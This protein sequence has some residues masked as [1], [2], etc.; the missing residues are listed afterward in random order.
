MA[1]FALDVLVV[2]AFDSLPRRRAKE[3][4]GKLTTSRPCHSSLSF[5]LRLKSSLRNFVTMRSSSLTLHSIP[6]GSVVRLHARRIDSKRRLSGTPPIVSTSRPNSSRSR[7]TAHASAFRFVSSVGRWHVAHG[8]W[9][10]LSSFNSRQSSHCGLPGLPYHSAHFVSF[11]L[12]QA[13]R[14]GPRCECAASDHP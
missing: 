1:R 6:T 10:P 3:K 5:C 12:L 7:N 2:W 9:S 8:G 14:C 11:L 13:P 4:A